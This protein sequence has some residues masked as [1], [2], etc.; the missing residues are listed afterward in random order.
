[1]TFFK[2]FL[3]NTVCKSSKSFVNTPDFNYIYYFGLVKKNKNINV[4]F[5]NTVLCARRLCVVKISISV[6]DDKL[7][8]IVSYFK[9]VL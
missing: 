9:N 5:V 1:M 3:H 4:Y 2:D 6:R 8:D 7:I